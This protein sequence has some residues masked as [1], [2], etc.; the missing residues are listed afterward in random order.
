MERRGQ[1]DVCRKDREYYIQEVMVRKG[2]QFE[3]TMKYKRDV[4]SRGFCKYEWHR[5][6]R[7]GLQNSLVSLFLC[8][9]ASFLS[10]D[11]ASNSRTF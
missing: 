7:D 8:L 11:T 10:S 6:Q 5:P 2:Q 9:N 3:E 4:I 1:P